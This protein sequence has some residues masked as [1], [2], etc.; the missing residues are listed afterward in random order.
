MLSAYFDDSGTHRGAEI[1]VMGGL[2]GTEAQWSAFEPAW[3]AVLAAPIAGRPPLRRF[4]M[5]GCEAGEGEF[6]GWSRGERDHVIYRFRNIILEHELIGYSMA[7]ARADWDR[8]I[9]GRAREILGDA[10]RHCVSACVAHSLYWAEEVARETD[11]ALIFDDRQGENA[12]S[13]RIFKI[14]HDALA[15]I[16]RP[17]KPTI[18][19]GNAEQLVP[20]QGADMIAWESY[21]HGRKILIQ[22]L[23]APL[24]PHFQRLVETKRFDGQIARPEDIVGLAR[25]TENGL[26][27]GRYITPLGDP[28]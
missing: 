5:S 7:V 3:K 10:E 9:T 17:T 13:E 15:V 6:E 2:I 28:I 23:A 18:T 11:V 4:H 27:A 21:D 14:Y 22:G 26:R 16:G 8:H 24:R 19:F 25:D 12:E 1:L 20:L